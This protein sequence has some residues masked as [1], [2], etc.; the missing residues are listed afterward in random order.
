MT[1]TLRILIQKLCAAPLGDE[2][3]SRNSGSVEKLQIFML[4]LNDLHHM[5]RKITPQEP[6]ILKLLC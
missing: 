5:L 2:T 3:E 4:K 6:Q 1:R